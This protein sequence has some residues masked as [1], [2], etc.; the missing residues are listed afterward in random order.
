[1]D[2]IRDAT[3]TGVQT[4]ALPI[5]RKYPLSEL[6]SACE[7][8]EQK[9]GK[10]ITLEYILIA[11]VNDGLEQIKSLAKLA[12]RLNGKVNLI[13]YNKVERSEERRVGKESR[14]RGVQGGR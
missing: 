11:G 14:W 4:C 2:S 7:Y 8:F 6:I 13:P 12:L 9:K 5:Y 1:E 3:V 10:K